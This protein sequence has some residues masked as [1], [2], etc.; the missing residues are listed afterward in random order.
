MQRS[1]RGQFMILYR[2]YVDETEAVRYIF[3]YALAWSRF[4]PR[5]SPVHSRSVCKCFSHLKPPLWLGISA[6]LDATLSLF[7]GFYFAFRSS[8]SNCVCVCVCVYGWRTFCRAAIGSIC[9][10]NIRTS[11]PDWILPFQ[12]DCHFSPLKLSGCCTFHLLQS[13][14]PAHTVRVVSYDS[15]NKKSLFL[16]QH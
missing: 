8:S 9:L 16:Q 10:R 14:H 13:L 2:N 4:E 5:T 12:E 6:T 15:L 11:W 1:G 7:P 3:R